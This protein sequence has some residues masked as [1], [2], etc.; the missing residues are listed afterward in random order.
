MQN[1]CFHNIIKIISTARG[2]NLYLLLTCSIEFAYIVYT[3]H[4]LKFR[5]NI[6]E[7]EGRKKNFLFRYWMFTYL[8]KIH[9]A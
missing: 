8:F 2:A 4:F 3:I 6:A 7:G 5:M 9:L 1:I